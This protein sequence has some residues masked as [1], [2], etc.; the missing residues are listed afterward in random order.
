MPR[1]Y[2]GWEVP[3]DNL[4]RLMFDQHMSQEKL[5][6]ASGIERSSISLILSG[7]DFR[8]STLLKLAKGL[9]VEPWTLLTKHPVAHADIAD[10]A[11]DIAKALHLLMVLTKGGGK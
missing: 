5:A 7:S 8:M 3:V 9:G 1:K 4:R 2:D 11:Q 10:P 6:A